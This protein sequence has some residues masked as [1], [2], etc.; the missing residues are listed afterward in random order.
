ML[1]ELGVIIPRTT[2]KLEL[3]E[4]NE[5]PSVNPFDYHT[6]LLSR[7]WKELI[8]ERS[9]GICERCKK[10]H[11]TYWRIGKEHPEDLLGVCEG[12]HLYL[13][14]RLTV[15]PLRNISKILV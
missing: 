11:L 12:C 14:G 4:Y 1:K 15:D 9:H 7:E 2:W 8:Y 13:H 5:H 3:E 10:H 6:Y